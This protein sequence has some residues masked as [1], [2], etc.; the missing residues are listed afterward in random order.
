MEKEQKSR[1]S[2]KF[3]EINKVIK[4][5]M[6]DKLLDET[7][8]DCSWQIIPNGQQ[9]IITLTNTPTNEHYT[10]EFG[11]LRERVLK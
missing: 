1:K 3:R 11:C 5:F 9:L 10:D 8:L 7:I 6:P 2:Y 4:K